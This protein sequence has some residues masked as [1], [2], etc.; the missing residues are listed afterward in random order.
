MQREIHLFDWIFQLVLLNQQRY[1]H[2][3]PNS[4]L[5]PLDLHLAQIQ[6]CPSFSCGWAAPDPVS[7]TQTIH[8]FHGHVLKQQ[9][10]QT[11]LDTKSQITAARQIKLYK[12]IL[13]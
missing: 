13:L 2:A 11:K 6:G 10:M 5:S 7:V 8:P 9:Q 12:E 4:Q 3:C 1:A